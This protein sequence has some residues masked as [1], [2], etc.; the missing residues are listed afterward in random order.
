M[1]IDSAGY[2]VTTTPVLLLFPLLL[3]V[4]FFWSKPARWMRWLFAGTLFILLQWIFLANG[5]PWY[6]IG[7]FLG[8]CIGLEF[9]V[10]RAPDLF[11][12]TLM[13]VFLTLSF[14]GVLSQRFWQFEQQ[15]NTLEYPFRKISAEAMHERTIPYYDDIAKYVIQRNVLKPDR[16]YLYRVGTFIPYFIPRNLEVIGVTDHQLDVFNCLF[17]ERNPILTLQRL[18]ALGFNSIIFDTN[19]ATI[20]RNPQGTLHQK[21]Q[22]FVDFL[23]TPEL[24]LQVVVNDPDR[25]VAYVLIPD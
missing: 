6:G 5:I 13:G 3:F 20:E 19:T 18:K 17:Q 16:P 15:K 8:L 2:Y 24:G 9:L 1:N 4:P 10:S 12:R 14:F 25:G 11:S 22:A 21:V 23:N 7:V